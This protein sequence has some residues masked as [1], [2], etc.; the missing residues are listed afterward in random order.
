MKII[1]YAF[2]LVLCC[3]LMACVGGGKKIT[4]YTNHSTVYGWVDIED[5]APNRLH[6]AVFFQYRPKTEYP[7]H[8]LAV[9]KFAGGYLFYGHTFEN[10]AFKL[11]QVSGQKCFLMCGN[12]IYSYDFG[13]QGG[14]HGAVKI[15]KP[16]VYYVGAYKLSDLKTGWFEQGK[17]EI[18]RLKRGPSRKQMLEHILKEAPKKHPVIGQRIQAALK[19]YK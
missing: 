11:N 4:D 14:R 8:Y 5:A 6:Q 13:K 3:S 18:K 12:T 9:E 19:R 16:G 1:R 17:F 10:G 7:Y 15:Q 2:L